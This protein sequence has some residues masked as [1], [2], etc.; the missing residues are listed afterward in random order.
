MNPHFWNYSTDLLLAGLGAFLIKLWGIAASYI[1]THYIIDGLFGRFK[2]WL[3]HH[4]VE[5]AII[6]HYRDEHKKVNP[7]DKN[8]RICKQGYC[9]IV[10]E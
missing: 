6:T 3:H 10:P 5:N 2:K 1:L 4:P 9:V 8:P 7:V